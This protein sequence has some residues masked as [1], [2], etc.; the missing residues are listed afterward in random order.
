MISNKKILF[1]R[2]TRWRWSSI[3]YSW[4]LSYQQKVSDSSTRTSR[5]QMFFK[6]GVLKKWLT[7]VLLWIL[8]HFLEHPFYR[9]P[10]SNCFCTFLL[11]K[12]RKLK[13]HFCKTSSKS[14]ERLMQFE[15]MYYVEGY[16]CRIC[17]VGFKSTWRVWI[18]LHFWRWYC[19]NNIKQ[20][21]RH[22]L[23]ISQFNVNKWKPTY[24]YFIIRKITFL[25]FLSPIQG[26]AWQKYPL[27]IFSV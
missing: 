17:I 25:V 8:W 3:W 24:T 22:F 10:P 15:F 12:G 13:G 2:N 6:V 1:T 27:L 20:Q 21:G 9:T 18:N 11:G 7:G 23:V 16:I 5:S 14:P 19:L 4:P 26:G